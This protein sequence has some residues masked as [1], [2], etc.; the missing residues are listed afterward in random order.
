M[1]GL[2]V[3][4]QL[5]PLSRVGLTTVLWPSSRT[6]ELLCK[7]LCMSVKGTEAAQEVLYQAPCMRVRPQAAHGFRSSRQ[8]CMR[9]SPQAAHG[10]RSRHCRYL[11][12]K[13]VCHR[14]GGV[15]GSLPMQ[16]RHT[17]LELVHSAQAPWPTLRCSG[18]AVEPHDSRSYSIHARTP[19]YTPISDQLQTWDCK[20]MLRCAAP[21]HTASWQRAC[22]HMAATTSHISTPHSLAKTPILYMCARLEHAVVLN[23]NGC[24]LGTLAS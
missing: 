24:P 21:V 17:G 16:S 1:Q 7:Q 20:G 22:S 15:H 11:V 5:A 10:F 19:K 4:A 9:V 8:A 12:I 23:T 6:F 13:A 14:S 18:T 2:V 3:L